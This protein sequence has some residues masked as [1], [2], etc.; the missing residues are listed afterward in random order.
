MP[1]SRL[2][3]IPTFQ[4]LY[5][6]DIA[7]ILMCK[8]P[9]SFRRGLWQEPEYERRTTRIRAKYCMPND[10]VPIVDIAAAEDVLKGG[11]NE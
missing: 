5:T 2:R 6:L 10:A 4:E 8:M 7:D 9:M 1:G 11:C 3:V